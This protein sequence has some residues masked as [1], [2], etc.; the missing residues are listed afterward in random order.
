M[1]KLFLRYLKPYPIQLALI[2]LTTL[3]Q[4]GLQL[5]L[6]RLM[7]NIVDIGIVHKGV[8][9]STAAAGVVGTY[10]TQTAYLWQMGSLM[11]GITVLAGIAATFAGFFCSRVSA[12]LARDLREYVFAAVGTFSLVEMNRFSTASL[13]IRSTND[14]QQIQQMTFMLLR[15]ALASPLFIVVAFVLAFSENAQL[16]WV[17]AAAIPLFALLF[18]LAVKYV[19]PIFRGIQKKTDHL[20]L[21]AREG[22]TGVRVIRAFNRQSFQQDRYRAANDDLTD[23][24]IRAYKI[25]I[26]LMPA[27]MFVIQ[28][29]TIAIVWFGGHIIADGGLELGS[30][31]AFMQYV[32][33]VLYSLMFMSMIVVMIP[34]ASVSAE[35]VI[36]VLD[37]QPAIAD[38]AIVQMQADKNVQTSHF[39]TLEFDDISFHFEGQDGTISE[40]AAL[41]NI[42]FTARKGQTFAIIG[43]TGSGK[44]TIMNL[45]VRLYDVSSGRILLDGTDVRDYAQEDLRKRIGYVP[46][47]A[48]LFTGTIADNVRFGNPNASDDA[49]VDALK[50]AQAW[51]F[52]SELPDGL[53]TA[54]SQGGTNFSGGQ[55]QRL[56]I[57]RAVLK[58]PEVYLFDDSFSALDLQTDAQLRTALKPLCADSTMIIVAQRITTIQDADQ[59]LVLEEGKICGMGT[60]DEL[61]EHSATYREIAASQLTASEVARHGNR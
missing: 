15:L 3:T 51:D 21:I 45:A 25:M 1:R 57:A 12:G 35:R 26:A 5:Y 28:V 36:E 2:V 50:I 56:A 20:N 18:L 4:V 58:R 38:P 32:M 29:T 43:S 52:V 7:S 17:F 60:H 11:L 39:A 41:C 22:L 13:I 46:Q 48:V 19:M 30:M 61:M 44:S 42:S 9:P 37:T 53:E 54:V 31:M 23:A 59:I 8:D 16:S 24:N 40:T 47:K 27:V 10:A 14:I 6:P 49:V 55:R 33:W 34:R